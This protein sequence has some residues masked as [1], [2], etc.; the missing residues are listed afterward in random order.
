[1]PGSHFQSDL[2]TLEH[3]HSIRFKNN[4]NNNFKVPGD[5]NVFEIFGFLGE[6][7]AGRGRV[8]SGKVSVENV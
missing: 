8:L 6:L 7:S 4:S 1:M 3:G 5:S 2:I